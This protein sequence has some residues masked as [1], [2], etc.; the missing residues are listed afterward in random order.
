M[1]FNRATWATFSCLFLGAAPLVIG[2]TAVRPFCVW[3]PPPTPEQ[4][5]RVERLDAILAEGWHTKPAEA[6]EL[7]TEL[8]RNPDNVPLRVRLISYYAQY[9]LEEPKARHVLWLIE[10]HPDADA[11]QDAPTIMRL[12][13]DRRAD[14]ARQQA[15]WQQQASRFS[16]NTKVLSNAAMALAGDPEIA[17]R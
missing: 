11:F 14:Y 6:A 4:R 10:N 15:L 1:C 5:A 7:E 2:Q 13:S 17:L 8:S 3:G 16:K 12:S 9:V